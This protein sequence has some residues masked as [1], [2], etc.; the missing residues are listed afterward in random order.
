MF[1]KEIA[2]IKDVD[3]ILDARLDD[4]FNSE[5]VLSMEKNDMEKAV[6]YCEED[7]RE[8]IEKY[9]V[10]YADCKIAAMYSIDDYLDGKILDMFYVIPQYRDAD[11]V[12]NIIDEILSET[13]LPVYIAVYKNNKTMFDLCHKNNF[14]QYEELEFKYIVKNDNIKESNDSIRI[15]AFEDEV[16][17]LA[18]KY[19]VEYSFEYL[20]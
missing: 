19:N 8:N 7:I 2:E 4:L 9:R 17:K 13:Y 10:V 1:S 6:N 3:Y 5:E 12:R 20:K 16:K 11:T 15:N 14:K 18:K